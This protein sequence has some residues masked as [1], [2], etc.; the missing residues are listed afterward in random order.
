MDIK[1]PVRVFNFNELKKRDRIWNVQH[2]KWQIL[3]FIDIL[4]KHNKYGI[5]LNTSYD[6]VPKFYEDRLKEEK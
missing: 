6:G 5:F 2:G 4:D 3:T 1:E